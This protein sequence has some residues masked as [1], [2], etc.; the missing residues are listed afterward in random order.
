MRL[1]LKILFYFFLPII[2]IAQNGAYFKMPSEKELKEKLTPLQY[3]VTRKKHTE[4]AFDNE[5]WNNKE[6]GIYVD[7]ISGEPLF[8][9]TDKFDSKTG[10]PSFTKALNP[11][12]ILYKDDFFLI[13]KRTEILSKKSNSHLGHVF[14]DGPAPTYKRYCVNS[15]SLLF[16]P[17]KDLE[18]K[19][20]SNY[21]KL[22]QKEKQ[23]NTEIAT[24]AGGCF[25]CIEEAFDNVTGV[26]EV[27][28][29][30]TGG[31][32]KNPTYEQVSSGKTEH[33]ESIQISYDP[34]V[35]KY[36]DLLAIFW[37][38]IDPSVENRQFCDIG[39][40]YRSAIFFHNT[41]QQT[42]SHESIEKIKK[43]F[44]TVYTQVIKSSAFY[45]AEK[46]H[47]KYYKK[48]P[49]RYKFYKS[50]CGRQKRLKEIWGNKP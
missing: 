7:R 19:G 39:K 13:K 17:L 5:Y 15:S 40:Q 50:R 14:K 44:P 3:K 47:Q 45:E 30:Y 8:S 41:E 49:I 10:W 25:W 28:V 31:K 36:E 29:G 23:K 26:A 6:P 34:Q 38:N 21:L 43:K 24:F 42:K 46:Y 18:K 20:H 22:F 16:I 2:L 9:S 37:K 27:S 33:I 35:V 1:L 12:S 32:T 11:D 48:N 4:P